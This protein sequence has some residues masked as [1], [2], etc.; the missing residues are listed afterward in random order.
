MAAPY[1]YMER[2]LASLHIQATLSSVAM[3]ASLLLENICKVI[4]VYVKIG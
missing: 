4:W 2:P 3:M 1:T